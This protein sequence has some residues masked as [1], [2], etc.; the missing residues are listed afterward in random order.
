M[1]YGIPLGAL[2]LLGLAVGFHRAAV[3]PVRRVDRPV[4]EAREVAV[5]APLLVPREVRPSASEAGAAPLK[6]GQSASSAA[7]KGSGGPAWRGLSG[8]L[9]SQLALTTLQKESVDQIL[10]DRA[11]EIRVCHEQIRKSKLLDMRQY[12]WQVGKMKESWFR[13]IDGLLD[14]DQHRRFVAIV[15]QGFFNEG[16]GI[17]EEAGM[18]V[19]D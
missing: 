4:L 9:A 7:P 2:L 11:E 1:K 12:E 5:E 6:S 16:L 10:R 19:L 3:D 17:T 8:T 18:T 13:R 15:E 14:S